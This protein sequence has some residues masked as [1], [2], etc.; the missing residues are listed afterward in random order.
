MALE[1]GNTAAQRAAQMP[2]TV[3]RMKRG[4]KSSCLSVNNESKVD[5]DEVL[6]QLGGDLEHKFGGQLSAPGHVVIGVV[7]QADTTE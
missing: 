6:G 1:R 2:A 7:L 5:E 4:L 3:M